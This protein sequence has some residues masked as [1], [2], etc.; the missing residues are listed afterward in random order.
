MTELLIK[1]KPPSKYWTS[2][3]ARNY[4][5]STFYF[6]LTPKEKPRKEALNNPTKVSI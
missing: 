2:E 1:R 4:C 5:S 3:T 6:I